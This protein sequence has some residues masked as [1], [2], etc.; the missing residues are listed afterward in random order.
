MK[1]LVALLLTALLAYAGGLY[2]PWWSIAVAAFV[3]ALLVPQSPA[4]AFF[5]GFAG[6]FIMWLTLSWVI[7]AAN[8]S[9]LAPKISAIIGLGEGSF[10]LILITALLGGIVGGLGALTGRLGAALFDRQ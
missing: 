1:T 9:V 5:S 4:L 2:F 10:L 3:A 6:S 7:D 8:D